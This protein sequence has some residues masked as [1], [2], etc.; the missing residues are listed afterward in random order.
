MSF[1]ESLPLLRGWRYFYVRY[2]QLGAGVL[3]HGATVDVF[4][5]K[6]KGYF[7]FAAARLWNSGDGKYVEVHTDFDYPEWTYPIHFSI[8]SLQYFG[9]TLPINYGAYATIIDDTNKVYAAVTTPSKPM[10]FSKNFKI[11]LIAPSQ[12]ISDSND[13]YYTFVHSYILVTDEEAFKESVRDMYGITDLTEAIKDLA[14]AIRSIQAQAPVKV[15]APA[16]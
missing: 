9:D 8:D 5:S 14:S 10:P 6:G 4:N 12:P 13:I 7:L 2:P 16:R 1:Y 3:K 15:V 11:T